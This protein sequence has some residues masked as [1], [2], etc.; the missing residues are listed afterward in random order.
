[1]N[2]SRSYYTNIDRRYKLNILVYIK[3]YFVLK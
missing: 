2:R 1:M 3:K